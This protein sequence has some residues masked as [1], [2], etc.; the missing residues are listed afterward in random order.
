MSWDIYSTCSWIWKWI[1]KFP[2]LWS[3]FQSW[4]ILLDCLSTK[5]T[6]GWGK[7]EANAWELMRLWHEAT[8]T[9]QLEVLLLQ[10]MSI[11]KHRTRD[12]EFFQFWMLSFATSLVDVSWTLVV[13]L[14]ALLYLIAMDTLQCT[15]NVMIIVG[16]LHTARQK[17]DASQ[18][19]SAPSSW[20]F[21]AFA[22]WYPLIPLRISNG[23]RH[24]SG[25]IW[26]VLQVSARFLDTDSITSLS[27]STF[28]GTFRWNS[29]L[30][31]LWHGPLWQLRACALVTKASAPA[32]LQAATDT[33]SVSARRSWWLPSAAGCI[34][35][36]SGSDP[37][38]YHTDYK[39]LD[40]RPKK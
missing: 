20:D 40:P 25:R 4:M 10:E 15:C 31:N 12:C 22:D 32:S 38:F 5:L 21:V 36:R 8:G 1:P 19:A 18:Q 17:D 9:S 13:W 24:S 27:P 34:N 16:I 11:R 29:H 6:V 30:D 23:A 14:V 7:C 35:F 28:I 39:Y 33:T 3:I 37:K 2:G 26:D